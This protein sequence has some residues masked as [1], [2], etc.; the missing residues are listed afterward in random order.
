MDSLASNK[1]TPPKSAFSGAVSIP[2]LPGVIISIPVAVTNNATYVGFG[3][4]FGSP[5][6]D[7]GIVHTT[8][9]NIVD[10]L[11]GPSVSVGATT[12]WFGI[13]W[14]HNPSGIAAGNLMGSPGASLTVSYSVCF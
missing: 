11:S 7:F 13:Q 3:G 12:G 2:A 14:S 8:S 1:G 6:V 4:G 10:V 9:S 5:G